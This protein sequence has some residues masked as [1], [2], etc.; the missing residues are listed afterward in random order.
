MKKTLTFIIVFTISI[1]IHPGIPLKQAIENG[2]R[3]NAEIQNNE[4]ESKILEVDNKIKRSQKYFSLKGGGYYLYKSEKT[5]ITMPDINIAPGMSITG[6]SITGGVYHN[7][8]FKI[9]LTQPIFTGYALSGMVK[10][11]ELRQTLNLN[12]RELLE[13][14]LGG[15]IKAVFF[16]YQMLSS[17]NLS[18]VALEKR[19]NNHLKRL[20]DLFKEDLVRKSQVLETKLKHREILLSRKEIENSI[21]KI[22]STFDELTGY[23]IKNIEKQYREDI[24]DHKSSMLLFIHNHPNL[25]ILTDRKKMLKI[26]RKIIKGKDLPQI[27]G[28]A[29]LHYGV[30]GLNFIGDEWNSYFQGG[31]EVKLNIFNWGKT[32]KENRINNYNIKMIDNRREDLIRKTGLQL[33]NLFST[34]ENLNERVGTYNDMISIAGEES[35][36][37]LMMFDEKQISNSDYIDS[38]L[39]VE[40]LRSLKEKTALQAEL[41]K[42]EIN[43]L[44]GKKEEK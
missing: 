33:S 24:K 15:R 5:E 34:L 29:E 21:L 30:P 4:L 27:G 25:K 44:V 17:Q 39:N 3:I 43:T 35:E 41:V 9:G 13:L 26:N 16:N 37:K 40:N 36:L 7:F 22:A 20:E 11:N 38:V 18:L 12:T 8:D 23:K 2:I 32:R 10:L 14:M 6:L 1:F 28:F 31:V 19:I 42:V